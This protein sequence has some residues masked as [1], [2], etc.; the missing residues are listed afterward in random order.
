M[1]RDSSSFITGAVATGIRVTKLAINSL[2]P[3]THTFSLRVSSSSKKKN[4]LLLLNTSPSQ[5]LQETI[6]MTTIDHIIDPGGEVIINLRNANSPSAQDTSSVAQAHQE[7]VNDQ[8]PN[9]AISTED[10]IHDQLFGFRIQVSAQ[11]LMFASPVFKNLLPDDWEE[12]YLQ[13]G[14]VEIPADGWDLHAFLCLLAAIHHK[15]YHIPRNLETFAK[16]AVIAHYYE[17]GDAIENMTRAWIPCLEAVP[18]RCSRDMILWV[19]ISWFF[20]LPVHFNYSTSAIM[21]YS[22]TEIENLG[23]PIPR[24]LISKDRTSLH[25]FGLVLIRL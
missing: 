1:K 16:V 24:Q 5:I 6:I 10:N 4:T 13:N 23:F 2:H 19:W 22:K 15:D 11:H 8:T 14:S 9:S 18:M 25:P 20:L 12:I 21:T 3:S 17:C 7:T